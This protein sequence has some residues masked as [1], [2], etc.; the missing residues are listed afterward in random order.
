MTVPNFNC[1]FPAL[2]EQI[3][4]MAIPVPPRTPAL[5]AC[6]TR[7]FGDGRPSRYPKIVC[8]LLCVSAE[9]LTVKWHVLTREGGG[10]KRLASRLPDHRLDRAEPR[11]TIRLPSNRAPLQAGV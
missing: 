11:S 6:S 7:Q 4:T 10:A 1:L 2:P 9:S 3:S 8:A 5:R